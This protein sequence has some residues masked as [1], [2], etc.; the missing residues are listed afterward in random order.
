MSTEAEVWRGELTF[1]QVNLI[2]KPCVEVTLDVRILVWHIWW[3]GTFPVV[4]EWLSGVLLWSQ[5]WSERCLA[6]SD[7]WALLS[8]SCD[9]QCQVQGQR[10]MRQAYLIFLNQPCVEVMEQWLW[11]DVTVVGIWWN[12][13]RKKID[14]SNDLLCLE[15]RRENGVEHTCCYSGVHATKC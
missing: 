1:W 7:H 3:D 9:A 12:W 11:N 15:M 8:F 2:N 6:D 14:R 13:C 5:W 10:H 4:D